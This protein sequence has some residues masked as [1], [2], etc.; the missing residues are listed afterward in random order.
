[1]DFLNFTSFQ[2]P[3]MQTPPPLRTASW[4]VAAASAAGRPKPLQNTKSFSRLE[5]PPSTPRP[6][7]RATTVQGTIPEIEHAPNAA[8]PP[9]Q[10]EPPG[11][12]F[13]S[14]DDDGGPLVSSPVSEMASPVVKQPE[15]FEELPIE[16]RSLTER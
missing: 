5:S 10:A 4:D 11:D 16:I 14:G 2:V 6:R 15:T 1:M 9:A 8:L 3:Q 13:T 7:E 12:I